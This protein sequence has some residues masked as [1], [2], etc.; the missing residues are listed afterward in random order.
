[1]RVNPIELAAPIIGSLFVAIGAA[2]AAAAPMATKSEPMIGAASS[3]G[4]TR[5]FYVCGVR[6]NISP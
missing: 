4:F 2:A 5:T 3:I 6:E 1:M